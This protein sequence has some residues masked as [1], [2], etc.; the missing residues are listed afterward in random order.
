M[1]AISL[2]LIILTIGGA[3]QKQMTTEAVT[4]DGRRVLLYADGTWAYQK[5]ADP[6]EVLFRGVKWGAP[7]DAIKTVMKMPPAAQSDQFVGY[8][9]SIGSLDAQCYFVL[10]NGQFIRGK[11]VFNQTHSNKTDF[12]Q[13]FAAIDSLLKGKYGEPAKTDTV[14]RN[15]LYKNDPDHWGMAVSVGHLVKLSEWQMGQVHIL[16]MIRGDNFEIAHVVEYTHAAMSSI[17][18]SLQKEADKAKL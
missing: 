16:H 18:Q 12:L 14:W 4:L 10:A 9:D 8:A 2:V 6:N 5:R 7:A 11:Y 15:D 1:N 3:T 17:E 13:D